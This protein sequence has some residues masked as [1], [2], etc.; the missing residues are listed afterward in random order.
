MNRIAGYLALISV[1]LYNTGYWICEYFYADDI[2]KWRFLRDTLTGVVIAILVLVNFMPETKLK[3]ASLWA[4]GVFCFG[5]LV[6][7]LVF[8]ISVFVWTDYVIIALASLVFLIKLKGN[9]SD[10]G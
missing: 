6:D 9:E 4:F 7:R 3:T 2:I 1:I 5:N 8:N 10:T